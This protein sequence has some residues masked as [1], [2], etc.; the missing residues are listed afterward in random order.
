MAMA[1]EVLITGDNVF[2]WY[3]FGKKSFTQAYKTAQS[4][5]EEK[6]P[7]PFLLTL[8]KVFSGDMWAME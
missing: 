6:G 3:E 2:T 1:N 5:D 4:F 7:H 8:R